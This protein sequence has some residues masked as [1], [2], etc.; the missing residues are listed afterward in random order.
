MNGVGDAPPVSVVVLFYC[1]GDERV[2]VGTER[3]GIVF[4]GVGEGEVAGSVYFRVT[5][6]A[7]ME[8]G[9]EGEQVVERG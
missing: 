7:L 9:D 2:F 4:D 1:V 8:G 6:E 5:R 3:G